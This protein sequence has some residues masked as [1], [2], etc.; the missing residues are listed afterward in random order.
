MKRGILVFWA[1]VSVLAIFL[2]SGCSQNRFAVYKNGRAYYF[3]SRSTGLH[4][5]LCDSGDF[6]KVLAAS[7]VPQD[8]KDSLYRYNCIKPD[9][10]KVQALYVSL[11]PDQ[12][13]SIREAFEGQGYTINYFPCG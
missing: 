12:R 11:T 2:V 10:N 8:K 3:A 5:M 9:C 7:S 4:K 6:K 13:T 1:S